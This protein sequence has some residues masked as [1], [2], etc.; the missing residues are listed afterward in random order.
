MPDAL[1]RFLKGEHWRPYQSFRDRDWLQCEYVEKGRTQADIAAQFGVTENAIWF[2]IKR[3]GIK[4]RSMSE[5]RA[6][7]HWGLRGKQNGMYDKRG[8]LS[9]NWKGGLTPARQRI[10]S[11]TKWKE[12]AQRV[13]CRDSVC[14]LCGGRKNREI[15][16]IRP[17]AEAPLL[18]MDIGNVILLCRACHDKVQP[19]ERWWRKRLYHLIGEKVRR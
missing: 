8:V 13:Y 19:K 18:V 6:T 1:G 3:H 17:F 7:K 2:W 5:I 9:P 14:R 10:Y 16:H 11:S 12:F 15:H 4:T